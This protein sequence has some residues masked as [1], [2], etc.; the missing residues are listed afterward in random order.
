MATYLQKMVICSTYWDSMGVGLYLN[1]PR[2]L[3]VCYRDYIIRGCQKMSYQYSSHNEHLT[4]FHVLRSTLWYVMIY[5]CMY[6][7]IFLYNGIGRH[8]SYFEYSSLPIIALSHKWQMTHGHEE[9]I[10]WLWGLGYMKLDIEYDCLL[11]LPNIVLVSFP[12][13]SITFCSALV[14]YFIYNT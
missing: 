7:R 5:H 6:S 4:F 9:H 14:G 2:D 13:I 10:D 1:I 12:H 8:M 11:L 3:T